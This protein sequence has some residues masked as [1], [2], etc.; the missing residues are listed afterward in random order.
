MTISANKCTQF[1]V[2]PAVKQSGKVAGFYVA[3]RVAAHDKWSAVKW[4]GQP[5]NYSSAGDA[6][7]ALDEIRQWRGQQGDHVSRA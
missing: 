3:G 7:L 1:V 2:K 4:H 5:Q 6:H